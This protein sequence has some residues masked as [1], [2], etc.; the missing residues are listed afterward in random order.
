MGRF[1]AVLLLTVWATAIL[2]VSIIE[3]KSSEFLEDTD[4]LPY[5][6]VGSKMIDPESA[7][8]VCHVDGTT[9]PQILKKEDNPDFHEVVK[10]AGGIVLNTSFNPPQ[11]LHCGLPL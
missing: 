6:I 8:A 2:L 11:L 7:P 9:R 5:M 10:G 3:E 1:I 4:Y